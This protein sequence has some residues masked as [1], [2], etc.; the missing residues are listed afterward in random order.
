MVERKRFFQR[1]NFAGF[2]DAAQALDHAVSRLAIQAGASV[3][4]I[5][6]KGEADAVG[7]NANAAA[8]A[9]EQ[10]VQFAR[11]VAAVYKD[12]FAIPDA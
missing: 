1:G 3:S 9:P 6:G 8:A 2:L 7:L 12:A 11:C 10:S 4:Q 5:A